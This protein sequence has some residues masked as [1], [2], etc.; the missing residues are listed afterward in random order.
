MRIKI[1]ILTRCSGFTGRGVGRAKGSRC[2]TRQTPEA[3]V[4][5][6]A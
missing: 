1:P 4:K 5:R 6:D 2:E 3:G